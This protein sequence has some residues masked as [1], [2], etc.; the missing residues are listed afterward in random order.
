VCILDEDGKRTGKKKLRNDPHL[1]CRDEIDGLL[2]ELDIENP[3]F[4]NAALTWPRISLPAAS[5]SP[6]IEQLGNPQR[7]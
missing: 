5:G 6:T 4:S 1:I 7:F 3:I 2:L